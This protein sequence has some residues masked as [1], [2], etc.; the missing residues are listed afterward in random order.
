MKRFGDDYFQARGITHYTA[1]SV[2][3]HLQASWREKRSGK[4]R[5]Y[6]QKLLSMVLLEDSQMWREMKPFFGQHQVLK[7]TRTPPPL[8]EII[9][10]LKPSQRQSE[11]MKFLGES[12]TMRLLTKTVLSAVKRGTCVGSTVRITELRQNKRNGGEEREAS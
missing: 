5:F 2:T 4:S 10:R 7:D 1:Q 6:R 8:H 9:L 11:F 12:L 3:L